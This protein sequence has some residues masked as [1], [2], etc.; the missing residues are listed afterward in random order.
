MQTEDASELTGFASAQDQLG[1]L[2]TIPIMTDIVDEAL[3][4]DLQQR[5]ADIDDAKHLMYA[6][7]HACDCFIT[8]DEKDILP[9]RATLEG[10]CR[11]LKILTPSELLTQLGPAPTKAS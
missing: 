11:G 10:A 1:G 2:V 7:H 5:G 4:R 6:V 9:I 8:L 3:L